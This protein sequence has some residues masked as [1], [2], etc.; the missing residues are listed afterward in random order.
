M[1]E[2]ATE[3][4]P[5]TLPVLGGNGDINVTETASLCPR[6]F[7]SPVGDTAPSPGSDGPEWSGL[8]WRTS[9]DCQSPKGVPEPTRG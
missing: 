8:G 6:R 3:H 5:C 4:L 2:L 9:G 7:H 1:N